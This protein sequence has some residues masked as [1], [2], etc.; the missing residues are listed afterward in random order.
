MRFRSSL[1][2]SSASNLFSVA[3]LVFLARSAP[4]RIV[5][6]DFMLWISAAGDRSDCCRP[7]ADRHTTPA[8][9]RGATAG[10]VGAIGFARPGLGDLADGRSLRR[11]R[12][13]G[14]AKDQVDDRALDAITQLVE[15]LERFVLVLDKRI[16]LAVRAQPDALAE[17]LH[18][19]QVLHPLPVDGLQH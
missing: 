10:S 7:D 14:D 3:P 16:A 13:Q 19:G 17:V 4:A 15:H 12:H 11:R 5:A 6:P 9:W 8:L 2:V 18:L 1:G